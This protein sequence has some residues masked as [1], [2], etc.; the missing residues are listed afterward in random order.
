MDQGQ[1]PAFVPLRLPATDDNIAK[2]TDKERAIRIEIPRAGGP[3]VVEWP[4]EQAHQCAVFLR[5]LL[6]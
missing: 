5:E 1:L 3:V 2:P 4:T 6:P